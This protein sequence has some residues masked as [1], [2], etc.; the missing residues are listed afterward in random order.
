MFLKFWEEID[1]QRREH[2]ERQFAKKKVNISI[3]PYL[4][5]LLQKIP[6]KKN[7]VE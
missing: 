6:S 2:V 4:N 7:D 5:V 3:F 1:N